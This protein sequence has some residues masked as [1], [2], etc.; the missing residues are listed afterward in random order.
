MHLVLWH[1]IR[2]ILSC[3]YV[4]GGSCDVT[5]LWTFVLCVYCIGSPP[6]WENLNC[7]VVWNWT[8]SSNK[9]VLSKISYS[10]QPSHSYNVANRLIHFV[11]EMS[12]KQMNITGYS[13][14]SC[15]SS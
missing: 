1:S 15:I 3:R 6:N 13:S 2:L 8:T 14:N 10:N 12:M 9:I 5:R 7:T 11:M 4:K